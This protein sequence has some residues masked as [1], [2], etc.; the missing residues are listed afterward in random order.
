MMMMMIIIMTVECRQLTNAVAWIWRQRIARSTAALE[1]A[2]CVTA[3]V[4][5]AAIQWTTLVHIYS[6]YVITHFIELSLQ[7]KV[8]KF[9]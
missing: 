5:T 4:S 9:H 8:E 1:A 6:T 3:R 7:L 2:D